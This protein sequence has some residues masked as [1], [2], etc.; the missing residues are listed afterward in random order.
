MGVPSSSG[1]ACRS[2]QTKS[3]S[4]IRLV[5]IPRADSRW[6]I[7]KSIKRYDPC[8]VAGVGSV[9]ACS[10]ARLFFGSRTFFGTRFKSHTRPNISM[11]R[12]P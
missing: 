11:N 3:A 5:E 8:T 4:A 9:G 1:L 12:K 7:A 6:P 10:G 2:P